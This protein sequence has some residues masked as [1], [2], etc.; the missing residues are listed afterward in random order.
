MRTIIRG[1]EKH[2]NEQNASPSE[3]L[4]FATAMQGMMAHVIKSTDDAKKKADCERNILILAIVKN[5]VL[6]QGGAK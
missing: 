4:A 3:K 6:R 5:R 2:L 1:I